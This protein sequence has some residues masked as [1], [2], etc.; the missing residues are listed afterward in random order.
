MVT[1]GNSSN[2][3]QYSPL[4]IKKIAFLI[5]S[6]PGYCCKKIYREENIASFKSGCCDLKL[7]SRDSCKIF[8]SDLP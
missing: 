2:P 8:S 7:Y 4:L 3:L 5:K 1:N 6:L